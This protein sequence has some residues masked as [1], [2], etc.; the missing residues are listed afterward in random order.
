MVNDKCTFSAFISPLTINRKVVLI[1]LS[2]QLSLSSFCQTTL[3]ENFTTRN[4]LPSA[5]IYGL[6]Q[7]ENH[8]LWLCTDK[9][10]CHYDGKSFE[11]LKYRGE[12]FIKSSLQFFPQA[13]GDL[14][15]CTSD[16]KLFIIDTEKLAIR[17]YTYNHLLNEDYDHLSSIE[18]IHLIEDEGILISYRNGIGALHINARGQLLTRTLSS[19]ID[20]IYFVIEKFVDGDFFNYRC[21]DSTTQL[22]SG[23][24]IHQIVSKN[25]A[26]SFKTSSAFEHHIMLSSQDIYLFD[27]IGLKF[28][29][30]ED[31]TPL[32]VGFIDKDHFWVGYLS[33]GVKIYNTNGKE[34]SHF[35]PNESV[36]EFRV[37][38][39]GNSWISTLTS[40]LYK[41][42]N[43]TSKYYT[44]EGSNHVTSL[45]K[46]S[47]NTLH[48]CFNNGFT[49]TYSKGIITK[50]KAT[51]TYNPSQIEM[52]SG[53]IIVVHRD[54]LGFSGQYFA[55]GTFIRNISEENRSEVYL[56]SNDIFYKYSKGILSTYISHGFIYDVCEFN[57]QV[58]IAKK[59]GVYKY[60]LANSQEEKIRKK[61]L[62]VW[63]ND[64]DFRKSGIVLASRG[65]G[66]V[67]YNR[68][69][70]WS[71][72]EQDGLSGNYI[73]EI[74]VESDSVIWACTSRGLDRL[75]VSNG[76]LLSIQ[77]LSASDGLM[78]NDILDIEIVDDL[79]WI[80]TRSGLSSVPLSSMNDQSDKTIYQIKSLGI[81]VNR[82]P[83]LDLMR[84]KY[85]D[86]R[87]RVDYQVISLISNV[88]INY[89]Y[90]LH[91]SETV[92]RY[93]TNEYIELEALE[94]GNYEI[95]IQASVSGKWQENPLVYKIQIAPP[96]Y[97]TWWFLITII[98]STG[99]I[100]YLF[101][102]FRV[103]SY[104]RDIIREI[105]R[106]L[107]KR[108]R[109]RSLNFTVK[110]QGEYI[111]INSQEVLYVNSSDNYIQI[112]T[113]DKSYI[114]RFKISEFI[115]MVPDPLEYV[116]IRKSH[117]IR[118]DQIQGRAANTITIADEEI[119]IGRTFKKKVNEVVPYVSD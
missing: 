67:F 16:S 13:N 105:L 31:V 83:A 109:K 24:R 18:D 32:R 44:F 8:R 93:T 112:N 6:F 98:T 66:V 9:G 77:S 89:R 65:N 41:A 27:A 107:L 43:I 25:I 71:V 106:Q 92:W 110:Q 26:S 38:H 14:W 47:D 95:I 97:R 22:S 119:V 94:P 111:S 63:I 113:T 30:N 80:A 118:I 76:S 10:I 50:R 5:E 117:I 4:N 115:K 17:P 20:S 114:I 64:I 21:L 90:K 35:L 11:T 102:R 55:Q 73:N 33:G 62:D 15:F 36:T 116:Q 59:D 88:L 86:N 46:D 82:K 45:T 56:A 87:I 7:D 58:Y 19:G 103:L 68:N 78:E 99:L 60:D 79:I 69:H 52:L 61:K 100:I 34:I 37:D 75:R 39:E 23:V 29:I 54:Q 53:S 81:T 101:F 70:T 57:N 28:K 12:T 91:R 1:L 74:Y 84:L 72:T 108:L 85:S 3:F 2:I 51:H 96:Y 104:N 40:G 49:Y 42:E 48:I